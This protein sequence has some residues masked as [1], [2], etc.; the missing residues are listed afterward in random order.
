MTKLWVDFETFSETPIGRGTA[1]YAA[2]AEP[3]L[4]SWAID[5]GPVSVWRI[6]EGEPMPAE[7]RA[8]LVDYT[9]ELW[10]HNAAFDSTVAALGRHDFPELRRAGESLHRWRCTMAQALSHGLPAKLEALAVVLGAPPDMQKLDGSSFIQTFCVVPMNVGRRLM[11]ADDPAAWERG[12][13]YAGQDIETMRWCQERMPSW[14]WQARDIWDWRLDQEINR[15]GFAVDLGLV[16]AADWMSDIRKRT[17]NKAAAEQ[18]EGYLAAVTQR[19]KLL[20]ALLIDHGIRLPDLKGSTIERRLEDPDLPVAARELLLL[21]LDGSRASLAKYKALLRSTH[22]GRLRYG[23]QFRGAARTGRD[24]GR[25]FQPQNLPRPKAKFDDILAWIEAVMFDYVV[26]L[27]RGRPSLTEIA[28]FEDLQMAQ[29]TLRSAIVAERGRK[30]IQCDYSQIEL[31]VAAWV[32]GESW[33]IE[34]LK[35]YD[36]DTGPDLYRVTA[37]MMYGIDAD[38][39]DDETRQQGKVADLACQYGGGT[40]AL[41]SMAAVYRVTFDEQTKKDAVDRWRRA[42]SSIRGYWYELEE[43]IRTAIHNPGH[44]V[45]VGDGKIK[46][47]VSDGWLLIRLPSGRCLSYPQIEHDPEENQISYMGQNNYTRKWERIRSWG[48]KFF[49]N[50]VQAI[51]ADKLWAAIRRLEGG[52]WPVVLRVHDELVVEVA[53]TDDFT[54]DKMSAIMLAPEPWEDGLPLSAKGWEGHRYRK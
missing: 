19:D 2:D 46:V 43:S 4:L 37:G 26:G 8:K 15:R 31:R 27:E 28:G 35:R 14:N 53:D 54:A 45:T 10:A 17:V 32:A 40:N 23:F 29:D 11:P 6:A 3:I 20:T 1:V 41:E 18:T 21:R 44:A 7:L 33:K 39:I 34:A 50:I 22:E 48:G 24:A 16:E 42:N 30:L 36:A 47:K 51:A 25:L 5:G 38:Q 52:G 49:E 12:V 9:C 13:A